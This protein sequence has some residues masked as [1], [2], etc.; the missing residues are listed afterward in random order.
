MKPAVTVC[1]GCQRSMRRSTQS[2]LDYPGTI[3]RATENVCPKCYRN[4]IRVNG[5]VAAQPLL[6]R[7][8]ELRTTPLSDA[9]LDVAV[10]VVKRCGADADDILGMLDLKVEAAA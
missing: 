2:A 10:L 5:Q 4:G 3:T 6:G 1:I 8:H 9:E 7:P